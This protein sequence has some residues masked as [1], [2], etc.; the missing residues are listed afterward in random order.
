MEIEAAAEEFMHYLELERAFSPLTLSTYQADLRRWLR[1]LAENDLSAEVESI[2]PE[3]IRRYIAWLSHQGRKPCT[4]LRRIGSLRSFWRFLVDRDYATGDPFGRVRL[5]K[6]ERQ[7]PSFLTEQECQRL[8]AATDRARLVE[9]AFRDRAVLTTFLFTGIRRGELLALRLPDVDLEAGLLRVLKGKGKKARV[10]PLAEQCVSALSDWLE[11]RPEVEH[12]HVFTSQTGRP[13]EFRGLQA[14]FRRTV[15]RARLSDKRITIHTLRHTFATLMLQ[16]GCDLRA[17][18]ELMG[19]ESLDTTAIYL[20]VDIRS[21]RKAVSA[22]PLAQGSTPK[23]HSEPPVQ[24]RRGSQDEVG[25]PSSNERP[26][27]RLVDSSGRGRA[28]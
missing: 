13:L 22:H 19:H 5:P 7:V 27:L 6:P 21:M 20:H 15:R 25:F 10:L 8:L 24:P 4:I 26:T 2:R 1:F 12:D 18:Q 11:I 3:T 9:Y 28:A 16:G 14:M 17:L 23:Q